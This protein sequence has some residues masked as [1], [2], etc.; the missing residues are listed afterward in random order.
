[1]MNYSI[2]AIENVTTALYCPLLSMHTYITAAKVS[3]SCFATGIRT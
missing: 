2:L 1:M 3:F